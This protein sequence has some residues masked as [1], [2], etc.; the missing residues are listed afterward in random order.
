MPRQLPI[1]RRVGEVPAT[2]YAGQIPA[3]GVFPGYK[4]TA[5]MVTAVRCCQVLVLMFMGSRAARL[6]FG[7]APT[8]AP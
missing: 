5:A 8:G 4:E 1:F 7:R 6:R 3:V 2:A